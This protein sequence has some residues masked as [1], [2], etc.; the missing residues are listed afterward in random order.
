[1]N[2]GHNLRFFRRSV[3]E[4][5]FG[6][7]VCGLVAGLSLACPCT[8]GFDRRTR[9]KDAIIN[10]IK[11]SSRDTPRSNE[12]RRIFISIFRRSDA[13]IPRHPVWQIRHATTDRRGLG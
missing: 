13:P 5:L 8:V 12:L 2:R 3:A 10:R 1:M 6:W 9:D 7:V 4:Y 11:D